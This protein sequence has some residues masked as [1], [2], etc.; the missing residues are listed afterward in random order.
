MKIDFYLRFHTHFGQSLFVAGSLDEL[1]SYDVKK[2]LPMNF[3]SE[4]F[5]HVRVETEHAAPVQYRYVFRNE[6]GATLMDGEKYRTLQASSDHLVVIDTWNYAGQFEN[7][8]YTAPFQKV[9]LKESKSVPP[10]KTPAYT[11]TFKVKAPLLRSGECLCLVGSIAELKAWNTAD[12]LLLHKDGEWWAINLDF[13]LAHFPI[14]YKYGIYNL[15]KKEFLL[16][17]EGNNRILHL[18]QFPKQQTVVHDGFL[19][20]PNHTWKGAGVAIP[21]FSLRSRESFGVGEFSDIGLLADWANATGLKMIQLLP[22][23]DTTATFSWKDSYPYAA[24]SAFALHPVYINLQQVAGKKHAAIIRSLSKKKNQLNDLPEIDYETV[25]HFKINT[26]RELYE[27]EGKGFLKDKD[28]EAFF[29]ANKHWLMPY[30]VFCFLRDKYGTSEFEKWK[31]NTLY[32]K[33]EAERLASAKSKSF[34]HIAFWYFVQ[35]HLHL[36]LK[37]AVKY[38]HKKGV[39]IKGDIPIGIYRNGC[40]AWTNPELYNMD[41]QSGAPPDDF[42]RKGQNWGFPTYNWRKMQENHFE[43]WR[44]RFEQMSHYFDAFRIDHILGFFRIWSIPI[45]AVE[46]IMGRFVPAIALSEEE[47]A[48]KGIWFDYD[49]FCKPFINDE[50]LNDVFRQHAAFAREAF[51]VQNEKGGYD[52]KEAFNRQRKVADYFSEQDNTEENSAI[53]QG[54]YDLISNV[55]LFEEQGSEKKK[56]HFRISIEQTSSFQYLDDY[57]KGKIRE[58]YYHYFYHRHDSFW[59]REAL[60]KL[61]A[62]KEVTDM[63]VCGE[64]LGMV[65]HCVPEVMEQLGILSLEIQ[66][67]PKSSHSEFFHPQRAP[68]LS[69]ITPSTHDMS[70]VREWWEEDRSKTQRFYN[71][72]LEEQGEAPHYCEPWISRAIMMQHLYSPAMWS[73]FQLQDLLGMSEELRRK[74][75]YE[76]R[77]NV[78]ANACHYWRYRMHLTLE[79]LLKEKEFNQQLRE[80]MH[81]SGRG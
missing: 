59:K 6:S 78:P 19:H 14:A 63:L 68:Y 17:E 47:F 60:G 56:F 46:G 69:V 2:A 70:T 50:I 33:E 37:D 54:L 11:H 35:Y 1:G 3:L 62:L 77:I 16:F 7:A 76:E 58:L 67:M 65:P 74:N 71:T 25:L 40:D 27:L 80:L 81:N 66:R 43:W 18:N 79:Q 9:L 22:V 31:T 64:D 24:I 4:D 15:K 13:S 55:L 30:A 41:Q 21:V 34:V 26:L 42:A 53:R 51:L 75:P 10:K 57:L 48:E 45:D 20:T 52:L 72:V 23:N 8:F 5:W 36:Q 49:R 73:I 12:P 39:A 44:L 28:F 38:A 32:A 61:P 29:S